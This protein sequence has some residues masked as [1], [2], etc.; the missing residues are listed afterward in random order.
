MISVF[1]KEIYLAKS[2]MPSC[3][4]L[5]DRCNHMNLHVSIFNMQKKIKVACKF[6]GH[7]SHDWL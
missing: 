3:G 7:I 6:C 5:S 4:D 1:A 2:A